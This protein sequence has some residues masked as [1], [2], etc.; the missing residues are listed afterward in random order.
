MNTKLLTLGRRLW[1]SPTVPREMNRRN[2][3]AWARAVHRLGDKWQLAT[4]QPR[5]TPREV[6]PL[7]QGV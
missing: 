6:P 7:Q 2:L 4:Y 3:L 5:K 1:S